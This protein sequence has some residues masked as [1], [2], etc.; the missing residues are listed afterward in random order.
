MEEQ[1]A[2]DLLK[3][4]DLQG[5]EP[6]IQLYYFQAVKAAYLIVQDRHE[7][8]DIVQ[9]TFLHAYEKIDQLAG[10]RFGPWF[11]RSVVNASI[12]VAQIQKSQ[13]S[14]SAESEGETQSMEDLL[15]DQQPSPEITVEMGE[16]SQQVWLALSR[17]SVEQRAAVVMK[18]YL[19]MSEAELTIQLNQP[20]STIKWW[21][22]AARE[23][24]KGLL[25]PYYDPQETQTRR[26]SRSSEKQD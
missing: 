8:E 14:L 21:L 23:R 15:A 10:N 5:L 26:V 1:Q 4:G 17:L 2:I 7:A 11:L 24:L 19:E 9:N 18:Y 16:L 20:K 3:E 25:H 13:I 12:K 22:Y 6:L